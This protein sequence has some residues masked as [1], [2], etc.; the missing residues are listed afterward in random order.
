MS[1][2]TR[3]G[4]ALLAM[5]I[6]TGVTT[7]GTAPAA[8]AT[9]ASFFGIGNTA[10]CS[11]GFGSIAVAIGD[12]DIASAD[13]AFSVAISLGNGSYAVVNPA[14]VFSLA[15]ALGTGATSD[16]KGFLQAGISAGDQSRT[17]AG[18]GP[19]ALQFGNVAINL[20][21]H[22]SSLTNGVS[23]SGVGNMAVNVGGNVVFVTATGLLNN[24]T[25]LF[26]GTDVTVDG[27]ALSSAFNVLGDGNQV[28]AG[29][30]FLAIAGSLGQSGA[31]V[32]QAPFGI[33]I[34]GA[35]IP[36]AASVNPAALRN[37]R[38]TFAPKP[39]PT[40]SKAT[41]RGTARSGRG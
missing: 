9:C 6:A 18:T 21:S 13:G 40:S 35:A 7:L 25:N 10:N 36:S 28:T 22:I 30:G 11:S 41:K 23:A 32:K 39:K 5:A 26:G 15:S 20:G 17:F 34:N 3:T 27:G 31:T 8:N 12:G 1:T 19:G 24:A 16:V 29:P 4:G 38:K 37:N 2:A 14:S 33:N